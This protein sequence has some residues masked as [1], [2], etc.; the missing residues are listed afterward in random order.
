MSNQELKLSRKNSEDSSSSEKRL[1]ALESLVES[2][3]QKAAWSGRGEKRPERTLIQL[4]VAKVAQIADFLIAEG[5][6]AKVTFE[7]P[8]HNLKSKLNELIVSE[9]QHIAEEAKSDDPDP[10]LVMQQMMIQMMN[11]FQANQAPAPVAAPAETVVEAETE[12][13]EG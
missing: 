8:G 4:P 13:S 10:I 7:V 1:A 5:F 11:Q 9:R 3:E 12:E 6:D 2:L